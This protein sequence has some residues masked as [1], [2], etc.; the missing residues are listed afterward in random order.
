M[1]VSRHHAFVLLA[2]VSTFSASAGTLHG[3]VYWDN[4]LPTEFRSVGQAFYLNSDGDVVNATLTGSHNVSDGIESARLYRAPISVQGQYNYT[5]AGPAENGHC[6]DT[7]LQVTADPPGFLSTV[8]GQWQAE[9]ECVVDDE[10]EDRGPITL[11]D[12]GSN[13]GNCS[14]ILINLGGGPLKLSGAEDPVDFDIDA[15]G[16]LNR[17]TWTARGS[18]VAFLALD[19]NDNGRIDDGSELFGDSTPLMSGARAANGFEALKELDLNGDALVD[20]F[21]GRWADVL[22][23]VDVNHDAVSQPHEL[24]RAADSELHALETAYHWTG[25]TDA[26]G[27][28]FRYQGA[29]FMTRGRFP[30]YDVYFR[31]AP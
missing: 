19:R 20:R 8:S 27:N 30:I 3:N 17:M 13:T 26:A 10:P 7:W 6:Y 1:P 28:L 14:P 18:A 29:A 15:N 31:S 16:T 24:Q 23:W 5:L 12:D 11:C 25:R 9:T 4:Q 2:V 21:D 22:L